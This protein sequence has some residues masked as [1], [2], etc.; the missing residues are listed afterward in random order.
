MTGEA[1]LK[2][3]LYIVGTPIGNLED[4]T[5]RAVDTLKRANLIVAE[6][7]RHT[8]KLLERYE[9]NTPSMSCH[10][11]NEAARVETIV[12]RSGEAV[13]LVTDSGMPAVSD[14]GARIV[15]G[16]RSAGLC[17]TVVPGPSAVT[18]AVALA[19]FGSA[20]FVFDAFLP[21]KSGARIR[22]LG[23]LANADTPVV[24][25][26]SPYRLLKL[27]GEIEQAMGDREVFVGRELTKHFEECLQGKPSE[28]AAAF[29][30]RSVKG[31]LV[32]V[33]EPAQHKRRIRED[34]DSIDTDTG[35]C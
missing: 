28:I 14:P 12:I 2:P 15:A 10:K 30:N 32:V 3:A 16:C 29:G 27:M 21:H 25:F 23:E 19:G 31:E 4:I 22:R 33:I 26:E 1:S 13:A 7:T 18:A 6:D 17:V 35:G 11:F 5:F 8:R 9:I 20:G 24:L 34:A